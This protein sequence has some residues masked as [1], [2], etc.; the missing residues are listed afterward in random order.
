[1]LIDVVKTHKLMI[2]LRK[3]DVMDVMDVVFSPK[4]NSK[5]TR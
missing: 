1:M 4:E 5:Y 2:L 3:M